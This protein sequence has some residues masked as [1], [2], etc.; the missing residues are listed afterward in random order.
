MYFSFILMHLVF[1]PSL[2]TSETLSKKDPLKRPVDR[3]NSTNLAKADKATLTAQFV[4][5][6]SIKKAIQSKVAEIQLV[7]DVTRAI[8]KAAP[9][10]LED[11][12]EKISNPLY[13][14]ASQDW[15]SE[16]IFKFLYQL[17]LCC[18]PPIGSKGHLLITLLRT[19]T[20]SSHCDREWGEWDFATLLATISILLVAEGQSQPTTKSTFYF[21]LPALITFFENCTNFPIQELDLAPIF[22]FIC[23]HGHY[24]V[25][26]M[27]IFRLQAA[28]QK[29]VLKAPS[30]THA[31]QETVQAL[32]S[33]TDCTLE[34][35]DVCEF[36]KVLQS[37][38]EQERR[39]GL[40]LI[41]CWSQKACAKDTLL[42]HDLLRLW[43]AI[44]AFDAVE[45]LAARRCAKVMYENTGG[46]IELVKSK[47]APQLLQES[48]NPY[49]EETIHKSAV[50]TFILAVKSAPPTSYV[51]E[52]LSKEYKTL[53]DARFVSSGSIRTAKTVDAT[54]TSR[55]RLASTY[56]AI[57]QALE[58]KDMTLHDFTE[59]L[60]AAIKFF[61]DHALFDPCQAV[62]EQFFNAASTLVSAALNHKELVDS[63][64]RVC[65][66][67]LAEPGK[68]DEE[69]DRV[70]VYAI[71]LL[72]KLA[73]RFPVNDPRQKSLLSSLYITLSTPSESVQNAV[74]DSMCAL[75]S[76]TDVQTSSEY[77]EKFMQ[78][79]AG[80]SMA[81]RRGSA[82]G[83]GAL[84]KGRSSRT[85]KEYGILDK[86]CKTI[87]DKTCS[88]EARQGSL[89]GIELIAKYLGRHFE[90]Y[91]VKILDTLISSLSEGRVEI[92]EA[93]IDT[94]QTM[95][96][97]VST[98]GARILL[99]VLISLTKSSSWR[100]KVGSI[101]WL[102]AMAVLSPRVLAKQLPVILPRL[103]DLL[104]DSHHSVQRAA[105]EAMNRFGLVVRSPEIRALSSIIMQALANPPQATEKCL[106]SILHTAF[107]HVIDGPSLALLEPVLVR[108]LRDRMIGGTEIKKRAAQ[109]V[110]NIAT[111]LADCR[112]LVF[113][114]GGM[115]PALVDC[116]SDPVPEVRANCGKVLGILVRVVG[117]STP[118]MSS[119]ALDLMNII[120][121]ITATSVDRAG[122]AQ[123]L[124]EILAARGP[125]D[126]GTLIEEK[127]SSSLMSS[128]PAVREG[129][130]MLVGY[131][132]ASFDAYGQLPELYEFGMC[133][134]ISVS[135]GLMADENEAVR[136]A[137][138]KA[139]HNVIARFAR[140]DHLVIFDIL[141]ETL[142]DPKWR[143]RLGCLQLFQ[144]FLSK[145][146][147]A[148]SDSSMGIFSLPTFQE[149][150]EGG[151]DDDRIK[152]LMSKAFLYRF[153]N[154]SSS[155]RHLALS[156]WKGLAPHPLRAITLILSTLM[157]ECIQ[158]G[159]TEEGRDVASKALE[160]VLF[161][162]GDRLLMPILDCASELY[163]HSDANQEGALYV[164]AVAADLLGSP[165]FPPVN[166]NLMDTF[167]SKFILMI[168]D[169][170]C[171]PR[172]TVRKEATSLFKN[173]VQ[174][175]QRLNL[176]G[177]IESILDPMLE[178]LLT[179]PVTDPVTLEG[180]VS[181]LESNESVFSVAINSVLGAWPKL[182]DLDS[183]TS[184]C[185]VVAAIFGTA[186]CKGS[187][188]AVPMLRV[189]LYSNIIAE[190]DIKNADEALQ[191]I[192]ASIEADGDSPY[193][194]SL[195]QLLE[196][197]YSEN[198][199][200]HPTAY[201]LIR[202]YCSIEG[203][204][205]RRFYDV[206]P[207][208]LLQDIGEVEA[209]NT[210]S[211][212]LNCVRGSEFLDLAEN[213]NSSLTKPVRFDSTCKDLVAAMVKN[214]VVPLFTQSSLLRSDDN[215]RLF[216]ACSLCT[217][218][219]EYV[220]PLA[221]SSAITSLVGVLIRTASDKKTTGTVVFD[222]LAECVIRQTIL[223]KPFHPQLQ[224]I[225][226][227][228][229][230]VESVRD[231]AMRALIALLPLLAR[232]EPL[233]LDWYA[234]LESGCDSQVKLALLCIL[235][236]A[237]VKPDAAHT[238]AIA[239]ACLSD[240]D[241]GIRKAASDWVAILID[242]DE[243]SIHRAQI[244]SL[245]TQLN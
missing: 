150:I 41:E 196:T 119:L 11:H 3:Q 96:R 55:E 187:S 151:I 100:S 173:L 240:E 14:L 123:A 116:L 191:T 94:I 79:L 212:L 16:Y 63:I 22:Q 137:A 122:A 93:T 107:A 198:A 162:L 29:I 121:G 70:R 62:Y 160:D 75:F 210:L 149:L 34:S 27:D 113:I 17:A 215:E 126:T 58:Q 77:F 124:A 146:S 224:R 40:F 65:E 71:V 19:V 157:E 117:E 222:A 180:L 47:D 245:L 20:R 8:S 129:F 6:L 227:N 54:K 199:N 84:V 101:E 39:L 98:L 76:L 13:T 189:I 154:S 229:L 106:N 130:I 24:N 205:L 158:L 15:I 109:I 152:L 230:A 131:L 87:S 42:N 50:G 241:T 226:S 104:N 72:A 73:N 88:I 112:D 32:I 175:C 89:F 211:A 169:G 108:A 231:S 219:L 193:Q 172:L 135:L 188:Q 216:L 12:L 183:A 30:T 204:D 28:F 197:L 68:P 81:I 220:A 31:I 163:N 166:S 192:L 213:I 74:A 239:K 133:R 37:P 67:C 228:A 111:D 174:S 60:P 185:K 52:A 232:P 208:R 90:P 26:K 161:K 139:C 57:S 99:P 64:A 184:V 9:A 165:S 178:E 145:F 200:T 167:I 7:T 195:A 202:I 85:I 18:A 171:S 156:I 2:K 4:Q 46:D 92:H 141:V 190:I 168:Q 148:E 223:V 25:S 206:W 207:K 179:D 217:R 43:V 225:F 80:K 125:E 233:L 56:L 221:W 97:A 143:C 238:L 120:G 155:I 243:I 21:M 128:K 78:G 177:T 147:S 53:F 134:I 95:M 201:R 136:D 33:N 182:T 132:P 110:G 86:L 36:I 66:K 91:I 115:V 140:I 61:L 103:V 142:S 69:H 214:I 181:L 186:S 236:Q 82:Y 164:V 209:R 105:R 138:T 102:G 153:D 194:I 83:L 176:S 127:I 35:S 51:L 144:E 235:H 49:Y 114:L 159:A 5:E 59:K 10:V 118:A 203:A 237:K 38:H 48:I 218:L 23:T 45:G 170:L 234:Q 244:S 242:T 44:L 1:D